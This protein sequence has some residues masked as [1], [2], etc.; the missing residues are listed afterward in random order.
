M[1]FKGGRNVLYILTNKWFDQKTVVARQRGYEGSV[2]NRTSVSNPSK[3]QE[4]LQKTGKKE[5][6]RD[7]EGHNEVCLLD[8]RHAYCPQKV[9]GAVLTCPR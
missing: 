2:P 3:D 6:K 1:I 7:K 8:T 4:A 9:S 5:G